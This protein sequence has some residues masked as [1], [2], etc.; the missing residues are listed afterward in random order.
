MESLKMALHA[1]EGRT[2]LIGM[3]IGIVIAC[4]GGYLLQG[5]PL[6]CD[7]AVIAGSLLSVVGVEQ[8][9]RLIIRFRDEKGGE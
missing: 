9:C 1:K 3:V 8:F 5:D 7:V 2:S 4:A 6:L